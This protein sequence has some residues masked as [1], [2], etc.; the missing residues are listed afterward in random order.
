MTIEDRNAVPGPPRR[1]ERDSRVPEYLW[2]LYETGALN[3]YPAVPSI[4]R[5]ALNS[6]IAEWP[7]RVFEWVR[8]QNF[9]VNERAPLLFSEPS[10]DQLRGPLALGSTLPSGYAARLRHESFGQEGHFRASGT[11]G[12]G[13]STLLNYLTLQLMQTTPVAVYDAL[14]QTAPALTPHTTQEQLRVVD[15][16]DYRRNF[17]VGPPGMDQLRWLRATSEYLMESLSLE[18][19]TMNALLQVAQAIREEGHVA[20]VPGVLAL[21]ERR[22]YQ[23]PSHKAL[24][25]RLLALTISGCEVFACDVGFDLD[26]LFQSSVVFNLKGAGA[27]VRRLIFYDHYAYLTQSRPVL[28]NWRLRNVFVFHEAASLVS[29]AALSRN[30][31][32]EPVLL[33]MLREARNYGIGFAFADQTPQ[34]EHPVVQAN[35]GTHIVFRLETEAS[36]EVFRRALA[37]T[38]EQRWQILNLPDRHVVVRRPDIPRPFLVRLPNLSG[39]SP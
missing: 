16:Y 21:L 17:L 30:P 22:G 25:N 29:R 28:T 14:N 10:P 1:R 36:V 37:L 31:V 12:T 23:S 6:R 13:K 38:E 18:P 27:A 32:G 11:T 3:D 20:T 39:G 8:L 19:A 5:T 34:V 7:Y 15:Y 24:R 2:K 9:R 26:R 33:T 35:L 4:I